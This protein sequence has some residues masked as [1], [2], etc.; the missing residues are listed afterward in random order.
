MTDIRMGVNN[1]WDTDI[2]LSSESFQ[3]R[4]WAMSPSES[5]REDPL[6]G[7]IGTVT[8]T[9]I[10]IATIGSPIRS[11]RQVGDLVGEFF[12]TGSDLATESSDGSLTASE[13]VNV[14]I[15][16]VSAAIGGAIG[17]GITLGPWGIVLGGFAGGIFGDRLTSYFDDVRANNLEQDTGDPVTRVNRMLAQSLD[18]DLNSGTARDE[19][20]AHTDARTAI[21]FA[22][23]RLVAGPDGSSEGIE[24]NDGI[25]VVQTPAGPKIVL[26]VS[27]AHSLGLDPVSYNIFPSTTDN[28]SQYTRQIGVD[29]YVAEQQRVAYER[30]EAN[31]E[32]AAQRSTGGDGGDSGSSGGAASR[33]TQPGVTGGNN[34]G[35]NGTSLAG[36]VCVGG[37]TG[38]TLTAL[39]G[40]DDDGGFQNHVDHI[41]SSG[42]TLGGLPIL[43]DLN[44]NGVEIT[45]LDRS[46]TFVDSGG[47]GLQ[48]R[49][50]W[51]GAGDGVLFY[52]AGNDGL[53]KEQRE[54][55][56]TEWDP[57][58]KDD[59]AAL[60]SR[61]D[62]NNDGK[63][64]ASDAEFAKFKVMVTNADGA[65]TAKTLAQLNITEINLRTDAT[66]ISFA[67]GSQITG[68][69][70]FT[71]GGV[72][73]TAAAVT[74]V[75]EADGH[76]LETTVEGATTSYVAGL[77]TIGRG[78][79]LTA[80]RKRGQSVH[81]RTV[82]KLMESQRSVNFCSSDV[83]VIV[84]GPIRAVESTSRRRPR[85]GLLTVKSTEHLHRGHQCEI[86]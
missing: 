84:Y 63:L 20:G 57:T 75:S 73:K 29:A 56:F 82:W 72:V 80:R 11:V 59:M 21:E 85:Q 30:A 48:H 83:E 31:R 44:G 38:Q 12:S 6:I 74:L 52:D 22:N 26:P 32:A 36:N 5:H 10:I 68:Q 46:T 2:Y 78:R 50:A 13:V 33:W 70:T 41:I 43:L 86:S 71:M 4:I 77:R 17:G 40:D 18:H 42:T 9:I 66:L 1:S 64:N 19:S 65:Q 14:G 49:T 15:R 53:I 34:M 23:S 45:G 60:R 67:D 39:T 16:A 61:F 8:G 7:F 25:K 28:T 35:T 76:K 81:A 51:A 24:L 47:D 62:S 55:V 58:A 37:D 79:G 54:Y 27:I 3:T 69:T